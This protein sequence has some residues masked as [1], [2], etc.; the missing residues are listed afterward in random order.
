MSSSR[1]DNDLPCSVSAW[2]GNSVDLHIDDTR[3]INILTTIAPP[4]RVDN[5]A[6]TAVTIVIIA[7]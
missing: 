1:C 2:S 7:L 5:T 3:Q 4:I 6:V